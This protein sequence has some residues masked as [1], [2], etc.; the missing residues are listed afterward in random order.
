MLKMLT[1][2]ELA[3]K[4][5]FIHGGCGKLPACQMFTGEIKSR[6]PGICDWRL[7]ISDSGK[8]AI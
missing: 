6:I 2:K 5:D 3:C 8:S 7:A 1:L 4:N